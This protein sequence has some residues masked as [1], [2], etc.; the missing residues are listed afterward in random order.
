MP[1]PL[2][3]FLSDKA[4]R[5]LGLV[6]GAILFLFLASH[7][8]NHAL[9][10]AS[11]ATADDALGIFKR[12]WR[13][14][15]G[16]I[17]LYGSLLVHFLLALRTLY[18]R[19]QWRLPPRLL[20][21]V[22]FGLSLPLL[23]APHVI[24]ARIPSL[25]GGPDT[26]YEAVL[27][28]LWYG[29][30][31][32]GAKLLVAIVIGWVHGCIGIHAALAFRRWYPSVAQPLFAVAVIV[33]TLAIAG[34]V[35]ASGEVPR[36]PQQS[37]DGAPRGE[38][39][40]EAQLLDLDLIELRFYGLFAG[41]LGLMLAL[42]GLRSWTEHAPEIRVRY[43]HGPVVRVPRSTT[44][45]DAS[46]IG[47]VNHYSICGGK[48]RCSTCRVRI[49]ETA[50]PLK[51]PTGL[52]RATLGR[53]GAAP[54]TRLACQTR[55]D[56]DV[57]VA[58]LFEPPADA[59]FFS[60]R[61][62][63]EVGREQEILVMFC[64]IRHFTAIAERRLPYDVVFLLNR[65]F[66]VVGSI[67]EANKGQIDKFIGDGVMALFGIDQNQP[68]AACRRAMKAAAEIVAATQKLNEELKQELGIHLEV[69]IGLHFGPAIVGMVG[70]G[71]VTGTTAIG[72]TVNVASRLEYVAKQ[73]DVAIAASEPVM[74]VAELPTGGLASR[75]VAI[76]GRKN[77]MRV[78]LVGAEDAKRYSA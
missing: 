3:P 40:M 41:S 37:N 52:E 43:A 13:N 20:A 44:I 54:D 69:A 64:D 2:S 1:E 22:I 9:L 45:L 15:L 6:S 50:G 49:L 76:R 27:R 58:L 56:Y 25:F 38:W 28:A 74:L 66:A 67:V 32:F 70:Y 36:R 78:Y 60:T 4:A 18:L 42:R 47:R 65:Y 12:V 21:Q 5:Q 34:I 51:P 73:Y 39:R 7:L 24:G 11:V 68:G 14:P 31:M 10:L 23:I 63:P 19:R 53:I 55:P 29:E 72:D 46:R 71:K 61:H 8:A 16:M 48:G 30:G 59:D 77:N 57:T 26:S 35:A 33:P 62:A 75:S 17:A